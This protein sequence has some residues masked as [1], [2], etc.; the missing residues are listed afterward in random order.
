[1]TGLVLIDSRYQSVGMEMY[2]YLKLKLDSSLTLEVCMTEDICSVENH[3]AHYIFSTWMMPS[4]ER[5]DLEKAFPNLK[6]VFYAAGDSNYF[7]DYFASRGIEVIDCHF[8]NS[9]PVAEGVLA[10]IILSN[11]GFFKAVKKY[12]W[13]L[14]RWGFKNARNEAQ[15]RCGNYGPTIGIVG[16]GLIA[17]QVINLLRPLN[18]NVRVYDPYCEKEIRS[19][20]GIEFNEIYQIFQDCDVVSLHLPLSDETQGIIGRDLLT[21][22]KKNATLI[23]SSRGKVV[24]ERALINTAIRRKDITFI[25]DVTKNEPILPWSPLIYLNNI[26]LS[27]H[28]LGSTGGEVIRLYDTVI[29]KYHEFNN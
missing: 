24:S 16:Y 25:L 6:S 26:V 21:R 20:G 23:N 12:K 18:F 14:W 8:E 11:K 2:E 1:M 27:P 7:R 28:I 15:V 19:S 3:Q 17:R 9:I 5:I 13:P 10:L 22:L 29:R 4:F